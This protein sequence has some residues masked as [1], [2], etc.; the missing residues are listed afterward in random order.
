VRFQ[1]GTLFMYST[2][3]N[4]TQSDACNPNV[5]AASVTDPRLVGDCR[6]SSSASNT[7]IVNPHHRPVIDMPGNR[8]RMDGLWQIDLYLNATAM[9]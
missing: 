3:Y 1:V 9:F 4:V 7:S 2:A 6:P 5:A 8:F